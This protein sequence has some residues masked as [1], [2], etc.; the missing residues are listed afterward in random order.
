[1]AV[2]VNRDL[3]HRSSSNGAVS[4]LPMMDVIGIAVVAD[5]ELK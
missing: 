2:F 3:S 4:I 1:M 5:A